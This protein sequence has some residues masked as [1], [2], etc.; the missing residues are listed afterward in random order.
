MNLYVAKFIIGIDKSRLRMEMSTIELVS[1][2]SAKQFSDKT[3]RSSKSFRPMQLCLEAQWEVAIFE[4]S[5]PSMYFY[6]TEEEFIFFDTKSSN[7]SQY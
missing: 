6:V 1:I 5:Y 7:S 2:S 4:I 3:F